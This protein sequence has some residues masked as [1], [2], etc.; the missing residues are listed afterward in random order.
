MLKHRASRRAGPN[1]PM[2]SHQMVPIDLEP[3]FRAAQRSGV[4]RRC[5][6]DLEAL[7]G[8]LALGMSLASSSDR[9]PPR[10]RQPNRRRNHLIRS[11]TCSCGQSKRVSSTPGFVSFGSSAVVNGPWPHRPLTPQHQ[12][13]TASQIQFFVLRR[14]SSAMNGT[15]KLRSILIVAP[16]FPPHTNLR[17]YHAHFE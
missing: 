3:L 13:K 1:E 6:C 8:R 15:S 4:A 17:W 14:A 2:C 16:S 12:A 7:F 10:D 11:A 9:R 5:G